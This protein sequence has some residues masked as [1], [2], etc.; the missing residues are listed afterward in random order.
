M[1]P[2][3]GLLFHKITFPGDSL[4]RMDFSQVSHESIPM[5]EGEKL[6]FP[7]KNKKFTKKYHVTLIIKL[8]DVVTN[9]R[10]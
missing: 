4:W 3:F 5:G 2:T 8:F 7:S 1:F 10:F 6:T 9:K